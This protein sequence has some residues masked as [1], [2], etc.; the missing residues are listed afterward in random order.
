[1]L[2]S[3]REPARQ[4]YLWRLSPRS[5]K[6]ARPRDCV[7]RN[8]FRNKAPRIEFGSPHEVPQRAD[9]ADD[10]AK[11]AVPSSPKII[12]WRDNFVGVCVQRRTPL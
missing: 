1:M 6:T 5:A 9:L 2:E 12:W 11:K 8:I 4:G 7:V 10:R 3:T